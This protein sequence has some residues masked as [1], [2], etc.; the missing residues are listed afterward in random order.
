MT[1]SFKRT[2]IIVL[3]IGF[4]LILK[5][6]HTSIR[7]SDTNIY[8]YNGYQL[9]HGQLLYKDIFFTNFPL[10]PYIAAI[11]F[12]I[13]HGNLQGYYITALL[14]TI[15]TALVIFLTIKNKTSDFLTPLTGMCLYLFSFIVL[16]TTDHQTGVFIASLFSALSIYFFDKKKYIGVGVFSALFVLCK[17]YFI[18]LALAY[19][20]YFLITKKFRPFLF[21]CIGGIATASIILL[22]S[23]VFA[24]NNFI[25]DVFIYSLTRGAGLSK[26]N[27]VWFSITHDFIL[28]I[29]FAMSLITIRKNLLFGLFAFFSLIFIV[30]YQDIYYLYL[31]FLPP[32]LCIT[33]YNFIDIIKQKLK[34]QSMVIPSIL[35]I[36][37]CINIVIYLANYATLQ[38]FTG[39]LAMVSLIK[40]EKPD[41]LYGTNDLTPA[42]AYFSGIPMLDNI[43]DTNTDIFRKGF[44]NAHALTQKALQHKT[45]L[46]GHG[47]FYPQYGVNQKLVDEIF[48]QKLVQKNCKFLA[49]YPVQAEGV[50]NEVDLFTCY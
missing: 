35:V 45:I 32:V 12:F 26:A 8:F 5:L 9:L 42:L 46:V 36:V 22:P 39:L 25:R 49:Q 28:L 38:D 3:I 30:V 14:E 20:V 21:F 11:Y 4:W 2:A 15:A 23:I 6:S 24:G 44:L 48:D 19:T 1:F 41:K 31:N 7:M 37:F 13:L 43:T 40:Q 29:L 27:I 50:T 33:W 34:L 16:S 47:A 10:I 17:A 18:P